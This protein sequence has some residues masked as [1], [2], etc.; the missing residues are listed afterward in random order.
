MANLPLG[1][2]ELAAGAVLI[3]A[4]MSNRSVADVIMGRQSNP[5]AIGAGGQVAGSGTTVGTPTGG[6]KNTR[7]TGSAFAYPLALTGKIIGTPYAGTHAPGVTSPAS[8]QSDNAVDIAVPIGTAVYAPYAGQIGSQIG[9][10]AGVSQTGPIAG[11]RLTLTDASQ[12]TFFQ[13]LSKLVVKAGQTVQQGQ[14]LGYT[15]SANG[16]AHLHLAVKNGNPL[17]IIDH[18]LGTP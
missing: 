7:G 8:W 6:G 9:L 2:A 11:N 4:G 3:A 16:V 10:T 17:T 15:G 14:L 18:L 5:V 13:H 12:S 1:F